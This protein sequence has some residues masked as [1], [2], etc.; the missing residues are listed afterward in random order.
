M[1]EEI[2]RNLLIVNSR[3]KKSGTNSDFIY[4][5]GDN[6]LEIE[7]VSLKSVSIPHTYT[8]INST[9]NILKYETGTDFVLTTSYEGCL[10]INSI[11]ESYIVPAG[12]YTQAEF[13]ASINSTL[14]GA[15]IVSFNVGTSRYEVTTQWNLDIPFRLENYQYQPLLP[16]L[17][18]ALGF[19]IPTTLASTPSVTLSAPN[20]PS[21]P[22]NVVPILYYGE[23]IPE[24]QYTA[25]E[26]LPLVATALS[27]NLTGSITINIPTVPPDAGKVHI[28]GAT[29]TWKFSEC[30]IAHYLGFNWETMPYLL[31]QVAQ[32]K[33][34]LLGYRYLYVA[35]NT[36][37]NGYNCIQKKGEKTSIVG[38]IPI[39]S[40][41]GSKDTWEAHYP[42][43]K[44]Y[45]GAVNISELDIKILTSNN[46]PVPLDGADV[47]L[48]FEVWATVRL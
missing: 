3:D 17:W 42:V 30:D 25:A 24:G 22:F 7:A 5:L 4:S 6:S 41:Y 23:V 1:K 8:N 9:N 18:T 19:T 33:P 31:N 28:T 15:L 11:I 45:D 34:D 12:V 39:C 14:E 44:A 48:V 47:V 29:I 10:T 16:N 40:T 35:S 2:K 27:L 37:M 46:D 36:L 20:A 32:H 13:L 43:I 38:A 21:P 26:L